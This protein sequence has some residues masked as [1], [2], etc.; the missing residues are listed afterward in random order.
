MPPRSGPR[1]GTILLR[2]PLAGYPSAKPGRDFAPGYLSAPGTTLFD[3]SANGS[4]LFDQSANGPGKMC[5]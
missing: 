5:G 2:D 1:T 4:I 3:Q